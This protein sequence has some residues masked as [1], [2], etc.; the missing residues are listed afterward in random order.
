M[1]K[2]NI[3]LKNYSMPVF[4]DWIHRTNG[5]TGYMAKQILIQKVLHVSFYIG[6]TRQM[7]KQDKTDK[8]VIWP[9]KIF[10]QRDLRCLFRLNTQDKQTN[11]TKQI[12]K[13]YGQTKYSFKDYFMC[14]LGLDTQDK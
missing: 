12:N 2:Q 5:H 3:H 1:A 8:K 11:K 14:L 13:S 10:I 9:N 7:D 4:L 6:H